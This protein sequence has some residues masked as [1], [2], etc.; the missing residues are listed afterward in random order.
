MEGQ[1]LGHHV[2]IHGK[3]FTFASKQ[4]PQV[5]K[6]LLNSRQNICGLS[7]NHE[8]YESFG[9]QTFC[10][11]WYFYTGFSPDVENAAVE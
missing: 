7:K 4:Y 9:L 1:K 6:T 10:T 2:S 11:I 3:T 5:P 8:N